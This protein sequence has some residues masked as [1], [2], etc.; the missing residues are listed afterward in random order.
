MASFRGTRL[1]KG[2]LVFIREGIRHAEINM[3]KRAFSA[4]K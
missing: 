3:K 4:A 1:A 2:R